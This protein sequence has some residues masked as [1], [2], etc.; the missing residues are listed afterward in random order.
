MVLKIPKYVMILGGLEGA[1]FD[2]DNIGEQ[3][4]GVVT[5]ENDAKAIPAQVISET[6]DVA[7][8]FKNDP[9]GTGVSTG[10]GIA[11]P[12][13]VFKGLGAVATGFGVP[14]TVSGIQW[15]I[16]PRKGGKR[17][18]KAAKK[19]RTVYVSRKTGKKVKKPRRR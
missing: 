10:M 11:I 12:F 7:R 6:V 8:N 4:L 19:T 13:L 2:V 1:G 5:G 14:T 16:P 3:I 15:A 18:K 9:M 17:R